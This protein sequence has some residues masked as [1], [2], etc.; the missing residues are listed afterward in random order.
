[1]RWIILSLCGL[2]TVSCTTDEAS[3]DV[4]C[5][6]QV[7][8]V[9]ENAENENSITISA[10]PMT[11]IFD[12]HVQINQSVVSVLDINKENCTECDSCRENSGCTDCAYCVSCEPIC[13]DCEHFLTVDIPVD[14]PESNE[15]W[16][17]IYNSL[18]SSEPIQINLDEN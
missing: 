14:L 6:I 11:E 10:F 13:Q 5:E 8:S 7:D 4:R 15:Y 9:T 12:T 3:V 2:T 1:M 17:T 18:G 16:A